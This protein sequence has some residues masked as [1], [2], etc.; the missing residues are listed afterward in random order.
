MGGS[1]SA[2]SHIAVGRE[3]NMGDTMQDYFRQDRMS[4]KDPFKTH[5]NHILGGD[6][7]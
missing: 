6:Q 7:K 4:K 5:L 3:I 2:G 1:Q